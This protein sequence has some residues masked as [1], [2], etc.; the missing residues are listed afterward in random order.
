MQYVSI[1]D[2]ERLTEASIEPSVG[3]SGDSYH[4]ALAEA[5]NG[6]YK[7]EVIHR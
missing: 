2:T 5:I 4:N 7:T 6:R 3:R 1:E